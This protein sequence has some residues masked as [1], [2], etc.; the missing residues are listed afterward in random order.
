M[1][2]SFH[3][4]FPL[5]L[6]FVGILDTCHSY[7]KKPFQSDEHFKRLRVAFLFQERN[8]NDGNEVAIICR[9]YWIYRKN[10]YKCLSS[11]YEFHLQSGDIAFYTVVTS[12]LNLVIPIKHNTSLRFSSTRFNDPFNRKI[13]TDHAISSGPHFILIVLIL[14]L[15]QK[16]FYLVNLMQMAPD[17]VQT[18]T[19]KRLTAFSYKDSIFITS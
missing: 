5:L 16:Q 7:W 1:S 8:R 13:N 17:T 6:I 19:K 11:S 15:R 9:G 12:C 2:I 3:L 10:E 14:K 4:V 18:R